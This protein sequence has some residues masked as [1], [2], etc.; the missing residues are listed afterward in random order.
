MESEE[1]GGMKEKD[2]ET[3]M[4]DSFCRISLVVITEKVNLKN[5]K[6]DTA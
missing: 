4:R 5:L 3:L 1:E 2:L 6:L